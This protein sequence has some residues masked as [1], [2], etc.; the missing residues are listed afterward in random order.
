MCVIDHDVAASALAH[1]NDDHPDALLVVVVARAFVGHPDATSARAERIDRYGI[2]LVLAT[3]RGPAAARVGFAEPVTAADRDELRAAFR[4]LT[5]RARA[6]LADDSK[7]VE[8]AMTDV[9]AAAV[10]TE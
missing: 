2:D 3:P 1:L 7:P 8:R 4:D 5:H 6:A 10:D 9:P